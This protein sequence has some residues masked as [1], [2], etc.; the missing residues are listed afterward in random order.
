VSRLDSVI[1]RLSA[2]R[3]V[4][5]FV[6]P[7]V[8]AIPGPI[9][10]VGLGNGRTYDH[11]RQL[12]PGRRI[13]ALDRQLCAHPSTVPPAGDLILGEIGETA[14]G[15]SGVEAALLHADIGTAFPEVDA[16]TRRWLPPLAVAA[17]RQGAYVASGLE[18]A[19]Q[20]LK[21]IALPADIEPGRY[22]LYQRR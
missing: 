21:P 10:E 4:L 18:L 2:Q 9:I 7:F 12:L 17:T 1:R 20:Q 3:Y 16:E 6:A 15:L 14:K 22:Y 8:A 13:I 19:H 11:L 5:N